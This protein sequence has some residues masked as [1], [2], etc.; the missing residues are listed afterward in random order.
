MVF[1]PT[2]LAWSENVC[3]EPGITKRRP[4]LQAGSSPGS[5]LSIEAKS[6]VIH[7]VVEANNGPARGGRP[8]AVLAKRLGHAPNSSQ[9]RERAPR[10]IHAYL[11][12]GAPKRDVVRRRGRDGPWSDLATQPCVNLSLVR[13]GALRRVPHPEADVSRHAYCERKCRVVD[14]GTVGTRCHVKPVEEVELHHASVRHPCATHVGRAVEQRLGAERRGGR[15]DGNNENS[16]RDMLH[17]DLLV[18]ERPFTAIPHSAIRI[19]KFSSA[20]PEPTCRTTPARRLPAG[21]LR[22][23]RDRGTPSGR[24]RASRPS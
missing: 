16:Q 18:W 20:S 3:G 19:P 6:P 15:C 10:P 23:R 21:A 12:V 5:V 8:G 9:E 24:R 22:C 13:I 2:L 7:I 14:H 1:P 11:T 4:A 17:G